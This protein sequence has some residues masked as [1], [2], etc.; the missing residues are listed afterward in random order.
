VFLQ[1]AGELAYTVDGLTS[2]LTP[3]DVLVVPAG[4]ELTLDNRGAEAG[5]AWVTTSVGFEAVLAD[6]SSI[7]PPW[8]R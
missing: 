7:S 1:L 4:A 2:T 3:G 6:G 5:A 8:V